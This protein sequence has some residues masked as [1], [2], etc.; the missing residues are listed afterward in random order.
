[1]YKIK[2]ST[3]TG[4]LSMEAVAPS[5]TPIL[6]ML[7]E[8]RVIALRDGKHIFTFYFRRISASDWDTYFNG[9]YSSSRNEGG[10][11]VNTN[12]VNTA[13]IELVEFTLVKV[14]GYSKELNK[15][16]DFW[17]ILP[18][19]SIPVSWLLRDVSTSH[20]VSDDPPDAEL[21]ETRIDAL[22][23]Q[24]GPGAETTAF[25][26]LIHRF[27][28][29]TAAHKKKV[30]RSGAMSKIVGGS[31]KGITIYSTR[32]RLM[33][34]IYDE[35]IQSVDGYG[36]AGKPLESREQ[37]RREMDSYHKVEAVL[38]LFGGA[39]ADAAEETAA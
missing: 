21:V 1:L 7:D 3:K 14:Q 26:G 36:V 32:H 37:I 30:M 33:V 2:I 4:D 23:S 11:Q 9:I 34:E 5:T 15:P 8:P 12:D 22:W 16:E 6:L 24:L 19:H 25:K 28:P 31:R 20:E 39:E 38:N 10:A 13:G 17:K 27:S 35:L 29:P 18:R